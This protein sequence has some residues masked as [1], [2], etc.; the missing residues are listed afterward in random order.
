M[1]D[2]KFLSSSY[3]AGYPFV[4]EMEVKL[5]GIVD[6]AD[7]RSFKTMREAWYAAS[8]RMGE[9][10]QW[11][12]DEEKEKAVCFG[13]IWKTAPHKY[14]EGRLD[15]NLIC[16]IGSFSGGSWRNMVRPG[17]YEEVLQIR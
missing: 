13:K 4:L 11:Y 3:Q 7:I 9:L 14:I 2:Q 16:T 12:P 1:V 6:L 10:L 8:R 5:E 17:A 15:D